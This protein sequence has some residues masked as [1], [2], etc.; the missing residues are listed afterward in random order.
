MAN[1]A[2]C[3]TLCKQFKADI[4]EAAVEAMESDPELHF[5]ANGAKYADR[6]PKSFVVFSAMRARRCVLCKAPFSGAVNELG[7]YAHPACVAKQATTVSMYYMKSPLTEKAK[8]RLDQTH[9][10]LVPAVKQEIDLDGIRIASR[11]GFGSNGMG[12]YTYDVAMLGPT[13]PTIPRDWTVLGKLFSTDEALEEALRV[14]IERDQK[15]KKEKQKRD[16]ERQEKANDLA[17]RRDA[18]L[19]HRVDSFEAKRAGSTFVRTVT[20]FKALVG[21]TKYGNFFSNVLKSSTPETVVLEL[22][23]M[24]EQLEERKIAFEEARTA[25]GAR[26]RLRS[27]MPRH[28]CGDFFDLVATPTTTLAEVLAETDRVEAEKEAAEKAK[29][30]RAKVEKERAERKMRLSEA[31]RGCTTPGCVNLHRVFSPATGAN[32]P[33]CG[34]CEKNR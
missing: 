23:D 20:E 34:A 17:A 22:A 1:F 9:P 5:S 30:G 21:E 32:G 13:I 3:R 8:M 24:A 29:A 19:K 12:S 18:S 25:K 4:D 10:L 16:A 6:A 7:L 27:Q 31:Q 15:E 11:S 14:Q 28:R 2:A 26:I 33:I